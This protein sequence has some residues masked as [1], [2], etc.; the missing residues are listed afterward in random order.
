MNFKGLLKNWKIWFLIFWLIVAVF[1]INYK[2]DTSGASITSIE[3]NSSAAIAGL[4][5]PGSS[6]QPTSRE[7]ITYVNNYKIND[8][9]DFYTAIANI[10]SDSIVK[11]KTSQ[12]EYSLLKEDNKSF[13]ITVTDVPGSN[14]RKGLD[15]Q[16]GT[17]VVLQ[18]S[19]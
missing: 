10:S 15:L 5:N 14:L 1:S 7:V 8:A 17:R 11:I 18:P 4:T 19:G 12:T 6:I 3:S 2:F 9:V 13:G 16:G